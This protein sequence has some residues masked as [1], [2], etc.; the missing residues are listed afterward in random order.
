MGLQS[1]E[2]AVGYLP[3][4]STTVATLDMLVIVVVCNQCLL[5]LSLPSF[6]QQI[7]MLQGEKTLSHVYKHTVCFENI[8]Q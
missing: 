8:G 4:K 5:C 1:S 6:Y 2:V 3:D 7:A